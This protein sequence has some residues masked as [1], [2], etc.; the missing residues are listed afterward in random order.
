MY[1]ARRDILPSTL[2]LNK[3]AQR[4]TRHIWDDRGNMYVAYAPLPGSMA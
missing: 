2:C 3:S 1:N 4:G